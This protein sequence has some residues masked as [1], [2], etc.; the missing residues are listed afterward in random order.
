VLSFLIETIDWY[1]LLSVQQQI[2]TEPTDILFLEGN[3]PIGVQVVRF[4][5]DF[6]REAVAFEAGP[7]PSADPKG[8]PQ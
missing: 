5:F 7:P 8:Q 3:R 6:A 4:S 2:A 1:R